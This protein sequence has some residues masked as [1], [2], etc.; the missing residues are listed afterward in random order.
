[1]VKV[2]KVLTDP[3]TTSKSLNSLV[4]PVAFTYKL[5]C[6]LVID[7]DCFQLP[8][9]LATLMVRFPQPGLP[10]AGNAAGVVPPLAHFVIMTLLLAPKLRVVPGKSELA[11]FEELPV[12]LW[13]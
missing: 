7:P 5:P 8:P 1:M 11:P 13:L 3:V 10:E 4:G 2:G 9:K 12:A 6:I